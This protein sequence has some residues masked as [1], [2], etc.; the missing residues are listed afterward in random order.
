MT[1]GLAAGTPAHRWVI[2]G[3][4]NKIDLTS[5]AS[6]VV[7]HA[8]PD[9]LTLLDFAVF[10]PSV[11][12]L[13]NVPN[14][15]LGPPSNIAITPDGS[16]ALIANS[17]R[18]DESAAAKWVPESYVHVLDLK[19]N[20][21]RLAGSVPTGLQPS[22][23]SITRDG[24]VALVA[25][26]AAGSISVLEIR[27]NAVSLAS[28]VPVCEATN[29]LSDVAIGS[30]GLVLA[31]AQKAGYVA[32]LR[33]EGTRLSTTPQKLTVFGQPYRTVITPDGTLGVTAGQG[34]G[35]GQ[36]ADCLSFIDLTSN[37]IR[38][39]G[40]AAI[41]SVPESFEIS[42]DGRWIAA[43]LMNGSNLSASDPAYRP[44]GAVVLLERRGKGYV[45]VDERL[46]G[47]IPEGVA[48]SP[49]GRHVIVQ[50]HPDRHLWVFA[51]KG[52]KLKDTGLRIAVP[53]MASSLRAGP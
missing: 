19:S 11:Q 29:S 53:G 14:S 32:V 39:V 52:R 7:P 35:N 26:R 16:L 38:T 1:V 3:N 10:P 43:V 22:G 8:G 21:P 28:T 25:N 30:N 24:R 9:S 42:P 37:P 6:K 5:G 33:L 18:L 4:E 27:G 46:I 44:H 31:S 50:C 51:L 41:G 36:D 34:F 20:P 17:I 2:S 47:R 13:T 12:H 23:I 48:F 49:D 45:K 15:V 40:Y